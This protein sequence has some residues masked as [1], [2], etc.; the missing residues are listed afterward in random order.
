MDLGR[1]LFVDL[2]STRYEDEVGA[3]FLRF[4]RRH[5]RT[6]TE[7]ASFVAGSRHDTAHIAVAYGDGFAL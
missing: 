4:D 6:D 7:T 1:D 5:S 3:E 2:H